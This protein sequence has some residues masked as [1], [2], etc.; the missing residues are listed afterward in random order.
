MNKLT[1]ILKA[2]HTETHAIVRSDKLGQTHCCLER[3]YGVRRAVENAIALLEQKK[4][5]PSGS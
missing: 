3:L 2:I 5:T 1:A 4:N